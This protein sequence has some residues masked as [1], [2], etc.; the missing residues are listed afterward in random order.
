MTTITENDFKEH[1]DEFLDKALREPV[2][3]QKYSNNSLVMVA[4]EVF[5]KLQNR[6]SELEDYKITKEMAEIKQNGQFIA[7][8]E[9]IN[10]LNEMVLNEENRKKCMV[11][12]D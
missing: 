3:I 4:Y 10:R 1:Y 11:W 5:E 9:A 12:T 8:E 7:G 2:I 6:I